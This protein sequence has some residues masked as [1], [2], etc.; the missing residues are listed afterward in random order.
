MGSN[1]PTG[2]PRVTTPAACGICGR[3]HVGACW[4]AIGA[5]FKCGAP[6]HQMRYCPQLGTAK[7]QAS[8]GNTPRVQASHRSN[9]GGRVDSVIPKLVHH[10][11]EC[12]EIFDVVVFFDHIRT[13]IDSS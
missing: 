6:D 7:S 1:M 13:M 8:V 5:C 4:K 11:L 9:R 10:C 2:L 3:N 12:L